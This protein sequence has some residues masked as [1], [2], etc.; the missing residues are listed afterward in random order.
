MQ[1]PLRLAL[2]LGLVGCTQPLHQQYDLGRAYTEAFNAQADLSRDHVTNVGY[3]LSGVE[4]LELRQ[5][6]VEE[7]TDA[8]SGEAEVTQS[9][10]VQ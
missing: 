3:E 1:T 4:G 9:F 10:T 6:V 8:E 2:L 5:R 7:S